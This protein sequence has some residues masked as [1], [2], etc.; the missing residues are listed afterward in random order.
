MLHICFNFAIY[1]LIRLINI[2][3]NLVQTIEKNDRCSKNYLIT[4]IYYII[5][6]RTKLRIRNLR[7]RIILQS[8]EMTRKQ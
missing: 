4:N 1:K 8:V 6:F 5:N 3:F 7:I 2:M